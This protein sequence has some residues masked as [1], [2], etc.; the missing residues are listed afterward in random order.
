[1]TSTSTSEVGARKGT[2]SGAGCRCTIRGLEVTVGSPRVA[3][4]AAAA[5]VSSSSRWVGIGPVASS[6]AVSVVR[7]SAEMAF[8]PSG[9]AALIATAVS[10][11]AAAAA[12][13]LRAAC[14]AITARSA[15]EQAAHASA[16]RASRGR[17]A[18]QSTSLDWVTR[19]RTFQELVGGSLS[20]QG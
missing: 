18:E 13:T 4:S 16:P 17:T 1:M 12:V 15:N 11:Q 5:A 10:V 8:A 19:A 6:S 20:C 14:L 7:N 9:P 2:P 3:V